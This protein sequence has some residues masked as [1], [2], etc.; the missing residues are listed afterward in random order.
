MLFKSKD[1]KMM[2][3]FYASG[4]YIGFINDLL[5]DCNNNKIIGFAIISS[6]LFSKTINVLASSIISYSNSMIIYET[7]KGNYLRLSNIKN[8]DVVDRHGNIIGIFEDILF[9]EEDYKIKAVVISLGYLANFTRGKKIILIKD[10]MI[11][12]RDVLFLGN[13]KK[14]YLI[15][16]PHN[17]NMDDELYE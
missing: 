8:L 5:I 2:D 3:V 1:F 4:K 6:S 10:L 11:G 13:D 14:V 17:L 16:K 9:S 12:E 7:N 15:S